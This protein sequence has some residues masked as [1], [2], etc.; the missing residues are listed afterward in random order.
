MT[1]F[2]NYLKSALFNSTCPE[3]NDAVTDSPP[4][5]DKFADSIARL[6]VI[7]DSMQEDGF[8]GHTIT[9]DMKKAI[10]HENIRQWS[11]NEKVFAGVYFDTDKMISL[12]QEGLADWWALQTA[13][14][15]CGDLKGMQRVNTVWGPQAKH[16]ATLNAL[17]TWCS[18]PYAIKDGVTNK[19]RA[20]VLDQ[21]F[22]W[23]ADPNSSNGTI[24]TRTLVSSPPEII[25]VYLDHG[26]DAAPLFKKRA[27]LV[28]DGK[29]GAVM[30]IDA[31]IVGR[32]LYTKID[33]ETIEESKIVPAFG[34][35][36]MLRNVFNFSTRRVQE[37]FEN[38][39]NQYAA[40]VV[41]PF[42]D[43]NA[44]TI[45]SMRRKL[46]KMGGAPQA[47]TIKMKPTLVK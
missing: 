19:L 33:R 45:K 5:R 25:G 38:T 6:K 18:F 36:N 34:Q 7:V 47:F 1:Y 2:G 41:T 14:A 21:I 24:F 17:M 29:I 44:D 23:G 16:P 39:Q 40:M 11:A 4:I 15:Y 46:I 32:T 22:A 35:N 13:K 8:G 28:R 43:Y 20:P 30:D 42:E 9:D 3:S 10:R 12:C 26:V 27:E 31:A 37:I